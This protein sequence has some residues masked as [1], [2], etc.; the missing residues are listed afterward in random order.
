MCS[1]TLHLSY[2]LTAL[3]IFGAIKSFSQESIFSDFTIG[4][5][6]I[7]WPSN[8]QLWMTEPIYSKYELTLNDTSPTENS[9]P[10]EN[11]S[12]SRFT[13]PLFVES[14]DTALITVKYPSYYVLSGNGNV[15]EVNSDYNTAAIC[16]DVNK[17]TA[18]Y[19]PDYAPGREVFS[20][21]LIFTDREPL[22]EQNHPDCIADPDRHKILDLRQ[23]PP[24]HLRSYHDRASIAHTGA[25]LETL[26][27]G[28]FIP[29]RDE[30]GQ[31]FILIITPELDGQAEIK[32]IAISQRFEYQW[33]E[34]MPHFTDDSSLSWT[35]GEKLAP[36][37]IHRLLSKDVAN[38]SE[39]SK[40]EQF[41]E[42]SLKLII[43]DRTKT[44]QIIELPFNRVFG[45]YIGHLWGADN[46]PATVLLDEKS[47]K[48]AL[49]K[50]QQDPAFDAFFKLALR[51]TT[52]YGLSANNRQ[53]DW[54]RENQF[55][56]TT[57][58]M[59]LSIASLIND[60]DDLMKLQDAYGHSRVHEFG[61]YLV[62]D[63][64]ALDF[65]AYF[66]YC[67]ILEYA[68]DRGI[69]LAYAFLFLFFCIRDLLETL[70]KG[71][72]PEHLVSTFEGNLQKHE[73]WEKVNKAM[74]EK[75]EEKQ[76]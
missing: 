34:L 23:I 17:A 31:S 9:S 14:N 25:G 32:K 24:E 50:L 69:P 22:T 59:A 26:R 49:D 65:H 57:Q 52:F 37:R 1:T 58:R 20:D 62:A 33:Q 63:P 45:F 68:I 53:D 19:V 70:G 27:P 36:V 75:E 51:C 55:R 40:K 35:I 56:I 71:V 61:W 7:K 11:S 38:T 64:L 15:T 5:G 41:V 46:R 39:T 4:F 6:N 54:C 12:P 28:L 13:M 66:I 42:N 44:P 76:N 18:L 60:H 30:K 3:F 21:V 10:I 8:D 67:D 2:A 47:E 16:L 29:Y 72:T 43:F 48:E 73:L 74:E